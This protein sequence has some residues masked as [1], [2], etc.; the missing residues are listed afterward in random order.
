MSLA[1]PQAAGLV[2]CAARP[3]QNANACAGLHFGSI[4]QKDALKTRSAY[5]LSMTAST[6]IERCGQ[7][8][9][10]TFPYRTTRR[11]YGDSS[12][13]DSRCHA[14]TLANRLPTRQ[15]RTYVFAGEFPTNTQVRFNFRKSC[16]GGCPHPPLQEHNRDVYSISITE[17]N[18]N[19]SLAI[20]YCV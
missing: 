5:R 6:R 1:L 10:V 14:R 7:H 16:R 3:L 2:H 13:N 19:P 15:L 17:Q 8:T 4:R 11:L 9:K 12:P 18:R 20:D